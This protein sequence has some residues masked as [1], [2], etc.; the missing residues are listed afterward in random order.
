MLYTGDER[1]TA[2]SIVVQGST[3][4]PAGVA[5]GQGM[6]CVG[7]HLKRLYLKFA[8]GGQI[9]AP[10]GSDPSIHARSAALGDPLSPGTLRYYFVYYRDPLVVGGCPLSSGFNATDTLQLVW[11][12]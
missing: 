4:I 5:F 10:A 12:P 6:R 11:R 7:G 1:P 9:T 8:S 3:A 2:P